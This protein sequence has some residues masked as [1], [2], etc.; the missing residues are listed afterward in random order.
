MCNLVVLKS[1]WT[2]FFTHYDI[3]IHYCVIRICILVLKIWHHKSWGWCHNGHCFA[4]QLYRIFHDYEFR[5][6]IIFLTTVNSHIMTVRP[7]W[8]LFCVPLLHVDLLVMKL[9]HKLWWWHHNV[10]YFTHHCDI[11]ISDCDIIFTDSELRIDIILLTTWELVILTS[12]LVILKAD[13]ILFCTP[14]WII[15]D[16]EVSMDNMFRST[17][18]SS[19]MVLI[20]QWT[21]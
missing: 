2:L 7:E 10:H 12:Y 9:W 15:Q 19:F 21:L 13:F 4:Q 8:T 20:S 18:T 1:E 11:I 6:D 3:I 14:Q 17:V 5:M 16:C